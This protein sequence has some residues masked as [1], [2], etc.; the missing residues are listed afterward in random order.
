M[1]SILKA[2]DENN[3]WVI[4]L[5]VNAVDTYPVNTIDFVEIQDFYNPKNFNVLPT[6]TSLSVNR[7]IS[8]KF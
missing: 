5:G 4:S 1:C 7:H 6:L 2:Q 8:C 3:P